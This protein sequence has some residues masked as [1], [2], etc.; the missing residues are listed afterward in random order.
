MTKTYVNMRG[1]RGYFSNPLHMPTH[2]H[3]RRS[4]RFSYRR[5]LKITPHNP[6]NPATDQGETLR[7]TVAHGA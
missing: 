1:L 4:T 6:A 2:A 7:A 3:T 5:S